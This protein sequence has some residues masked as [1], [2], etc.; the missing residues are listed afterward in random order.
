MSLAL[1]IGLVKDKEFLDKGFVKADG[2][3]RPASTVP[4][5]KRPKP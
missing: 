3:E 2:V 5:P 1:R 4:S